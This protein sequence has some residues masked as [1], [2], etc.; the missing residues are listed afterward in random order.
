MHRLFKI[1]GYGDKNE[2]GRD[3]IYIIEA[4]SN[5]NN[6]ELSEV[7]K[8]PWDDGKIHEI[9]Q[10]EIA[11]SGKAFQ[12]MIE[13][14]NDHFEDEYTKA[15][16]REIILQAKIYARM[17]PDHKALLVEQLQSNLNDMIG[18][19]GDGA[20]D[21]KALKT[22]DVGLSLSEAEASIAA[23]FTSKIQDISPIIK[24]LREG[25]TSLVT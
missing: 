23:P 13:S 5:E 1:S 22:A 16:Y 14:M 3:R 8:V 9:K 17:S 15:M 24:L 20:N 11:I 21:C 19:C 12:F 6:S 18:M 4:F 7:E 25:R 10:F 2:N